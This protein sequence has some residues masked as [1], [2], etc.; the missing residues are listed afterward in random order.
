M[1]FET[2]KDIV[3]LQISD[4]KWEKLYKLFSDYDIVWIA[5]PVIIVSE[6]I[7]VPVLILTLILTAIFFIK[8]KRNKAR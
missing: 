2:S 5:V 8:K 3:S 1:D 6:I 7:V 4:D